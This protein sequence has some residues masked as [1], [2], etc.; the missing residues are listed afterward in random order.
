MEGDTLSGVV[1]VFGTRTLRDGVYHEFAPT[2]FGKS[3][4]KALGFYSHDTDKPLARPTLSITDGK[5][6]YSMV[7]GH[8]SYA[9]DLREN[10][11]LGLM[12]KMSFGVFP[13]KWKDQRQ[14]DGSVVRTHTASTLYDIS[15]VAMPAFEGTVAALHS[16]QPGDN[17]REL[18]A[19][20]RA[21]VSQEAYRNG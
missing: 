2:A 21:R 5:L 8:Q 12:D 9:E 13:A 18:M 20:A 1:H 11:R 7:L 16:D 3:L 17:R 4:G 10:V 6:H 19:R 15:P 14:D